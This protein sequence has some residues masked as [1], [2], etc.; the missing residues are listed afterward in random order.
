[1]GVEAPRIRSI[2]DLPGPRGLPLI[3]ST[4]KVIR[5]PS[6]HRTFEAWAKRY[7]PILRVTGGRRRVIVISDFDEINTILRD[8]PDGFR[9]WSQQQKISQEMLDS[10]SLV[11]AEGDDWKRQ[12][13]LVV[14]AL[15]TNHLHL[16]FDV[17][18]TSTDRLYKRFAEAAS[19]GRV[20]EI[21]KDLTSYTVDITSALAFGEDLNTL[22]RG[23]NELQV[24]IQRLLQMTAR[25]M[26][27]PVRY[28]RWFRLPADRA[29]DHSVSEIYTA[30]IE[31]IEQARTR[32]R[33]RPELRE[34]P[35][36]FLEGMVA[37][38][39]AD[40]SYTDNEIVG[41]TLAV[42]TAGED[43]TALTLGWAIWFIASRPEI[44]ERLAQE[45]DEVMGEDV[46]PRE[47]EAI[48][49][50][51]Y[52]EAVLREAIRLRSV[53]PALTLEPL[54]DTTI[55]DTR[56]PAGTLM[57][58]L[59]HYASLQADDSERQESFEPERWLGSGEQTPNQKT[60]LG[61]GAGPRFCPGHNLAFLEAKTALSMFAHNFQVELDDSQGPVKEYFT[62][63]MAPSNLRVRLR[64][65]A[66]T[67]TST[68]TQS[69][70]L[71]AT[72]GCP[73]AGS[74]A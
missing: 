30:V 50:L 24:H 21:Q 63:T 37:A 26:A 58:L 25:R 32:L 70:S 31:F 35:E 36:N 4:L 34:A 52:S 13:R 41:N 61:F 15:N 27:L 8:R 38:Q 72:G 33:E 22:E 6:M 23:E 48:A 17:I 46:F 14:T 66:A 55:C 45:A 18:A 62:F 42:L 49:R 57:I 12:R 47:H 16:Y 53:V 20:I 69:L 60:F 1:M 2:D 9:R 65:R 73:H 68:P 59:T 40:G 10:S 3:G 67:P 5:S 28:W 11:Y 19:D 56:I 44:Q 7:G 54:M 29:L 43:T 51:R 64:K 74:S 39:D 71:S